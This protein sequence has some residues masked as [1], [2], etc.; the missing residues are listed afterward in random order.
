MNIEEYKSL[1]R[2]RRVEEF[3]SPYEIAYTAFTELDY[4]K[5]GSEFFSCNASQI[6]EVMRK[7]CWKDF[8]LYEQEFTAKRLM[9]LIDPDEV[10]SMNSIE[11]LTFFLSN[12]SEYIYQLSLSNTQSRR[13]RAGTEF[14]AIIELVLMGADIPLDSQGLIGKKLFVDIGVPKLVDVV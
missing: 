6:V 11:A 9:D 3:P 12:F 4:H 7:Q 14:E 2:K 8:Q 10:K 5:Q 1:V 13:S